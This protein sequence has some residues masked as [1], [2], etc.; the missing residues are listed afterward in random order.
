VEWGNGKFSKRVPTDK[1]LM[2]EFGQE[3][4]HF[5]EESTIFLQASQ[6]GDGPEKSLANRSR[7]VLD[8]L[9]LQGEGTR[10]KCSFCGKNSTLM[11]RF[12][13]IPPE[14]VKARLGLALGHSP[15]LMRRWFAEE[16]SRTATL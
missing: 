4:L 15:H 10:E 2:D 6:H 13:I 12:L 14:C 5:A 1:L 8:L 9:V 7:A 3:E 16:V 11:L